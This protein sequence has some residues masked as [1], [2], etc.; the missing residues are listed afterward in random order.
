[1]AKKTSL[2]KEVEQML[3]NWDKQRR[4]ATKEQKH[5]LLVEAGKELALFC[6]LNDAYGIKTNDS[7]EALITGFLND[8]PKAQKEV[9]A[10]YHLIKEMPK[11]VRLMASSISFSII[12]GKLQIH[13]NWQHISDSKLQ[14]LS[15]LIKQRAENSQPL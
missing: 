12:K 9:L 14:Q 15:E 10:Y 3:R 2:P 11:L 13:Y 6:I 8:Y 5:K 1:M 7:D 4:R